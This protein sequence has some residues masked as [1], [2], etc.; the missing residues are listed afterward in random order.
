[1]STSRQSFIAAS[2]AIFITACAT[3]GALEGED[4]TPLYA[5]AGETIDIDD[6]KADDGSEI[7]VRA[8]GLSVW[9]RPVI[10]VREESGE[11]RLIIR[12]RASRN[13]ASA[14]SFVPDDPL[15]TA[16]VVGRRGFE[17]VLSSHEASSLVSGLPLFVS[18]DAPG[19]PHDTYV[20]QIRGR[21]Q[22]THFVGSP[23]IRVDSSMMSV[24]AGTE[25]VYRGR[26]MVAEGFDSLFA[27]IEDAAV[28]IRHDGD[29][30]FR[31]EMTY[32]QIASAHT[33]RAEIAFVEH[34]RAFSAR[35]S[36]R[37]S[38]LVSRIAATHL[39]P[40][41]AWPP[42]GCD[43]E[44]LEC[45]HGLER[46]DDAD[47]CG[48]AF[49]VARCNSRLDLAHARAE[50]F[51]VDLRE[52]LGP[53]YAR[54]GADIVAFGGRD[55]EGARAAISPA[56]VIEITQPEEDPLGHDLGELRVLSHPD[57]VFPGSDRMWI[58]VYDRET[59]TLVELTDFE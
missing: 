36:A 35:K 46:A 58:G 22:L 30:R 15:G 38:M 49:A 9:I 51:A 59:E 53:W 4:E 1:M 25:L 10:Q 20:V 29:G 28:E 27:R 6:A 47:L 48:D 43:D 56:L 37:F 57:I 52:H 24:V 13:L 44:V 7:R 50:Q 33:S 14:F 16:T 41:E 45:L 5:G 54:Y 26:G 31:F 40:Y 11:D 2:A 23:N 21:V 3:G 32:E 34:G 42:S 19:A 17:I 8:E 39:D 18:L 55:L 12:G